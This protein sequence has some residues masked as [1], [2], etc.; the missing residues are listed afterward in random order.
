MRGTVK[1][2]N[3]GHTVL[4]LTYVSL[5]AKLFGLRGV[6]PC[7]PLHFEDQIRLHYV[8]FKKDLT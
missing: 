1:T 5:N 2:P 4:L 7:S 8:F 6:T 3:R